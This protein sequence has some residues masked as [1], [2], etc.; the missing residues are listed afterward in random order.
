MQRRL[1]NLLLGLLFISGLQ[2]QKASDIDLA[3][4]TLAQNFDQYGLEI[5]AID[6]FLVSDHYVS[7]YHNATHLYLWQTHNNIP[8]YNG[9]IT[10]GIKNDEIYNIQSNAVRSLSLKI[11]NTEMLLSAEDAIKA[12]GEQLG[13]PNNEAFT[14]ISSDRENSF[15]YEAPSFSYQNVPVHL[16]YE[17][18]EKGTY[19]LAWQVD[20]DVPTNDYWSVRISANDGRI[21]TQ[22]NYTLYCTFGHLENHS[23]DHSCTHDVP[24]EGTNET[25]QALVNSF[26]GGSYNVYAEPA[27]S[28][29][30]GPLTIVNDPAHPTASPFGW[31]DTD[32]VEGPEFTITRGNNTSTYLDKNADN[33]SDGGEP[34]G[35]EELVF[36]FPHNQLGEPAESD[37]AAQVNLFYWNNFLHDF[38]YILGFDEPSGNFQVNNYGN[39]GIGNDPVLSEASDGSG[40]NNANFATPSDGFSGRMQMFL[41]GASEFDIFNVNSPSE[42]EGPYEARAAA[43]G[44]PISDDPVTG[45]LM[46][47]DDGTPTPTLSCEELVN[48]LTGKIAVID[49]AACEFGLKSLNAQNAGAIGVI[50]CNVAGVNGGDGDTDIFSMGGGAFGAQVTIPAIMV[51]LTDCNT[52]KASIS[53]GITVEGTLQLPQVTGP[54]Q[55][56][57]SFDNGIIA[58]ELGHGISNRLT[59]GPSQAGCL[60]N[61]EQMGE[62][63][64]DYFG[65]VT[66]VEPGDGPGDSRG[67]GTY[68]L[69]QDTDGLGI[70]D[71]PY[72]RNM[73]ISPKTYNDIIGTGAPHPLGEVWAVVTWDLYWD[74]VDEYGYDADINNLESGNAR[75]IRLV[76]EGMKEQACSPGFLSGR[77]GILAADDAIYGG[78]NFCIIY[79]AFARR[80]MGFTADQG[81]TSDRNDGTED[82]LSHPS[83]LDTLLIR[84]E[85]DQFVT[86]GEQYEVSITLRNFRQG[87]V[88]I[89]VTDDV[90]EG[91]LYVDGS[92]T[93]PVTLNGDVLT[94]DIG[95]MDVGEE[96]TFT[97]MLEALDGAESETLYFDDFSNGEDNWNLEILEGTTL[98]WEVV[99]GAITPGDPGYKIDSSSFETDN[100]FFSLD[101]YEVT[102]DRPVLKFTHRY[103]TELGFDGGFVD[104]RRQ[105]ELAWTRLTAD[106]NISNGYNVTLAFGTFALPS[107][108]AFSGDSEGVIETI[109][110]LGDYV[111]ETIQVR[112]RY[113]TDPAATTNGEFNGWAIDDFEILDLRDFTGEACAF[114]GSELINCAAATTFIQ[115]N[116]NPNSVFDAERDDFNLT[117]FP[118]PTADVVNLGIISEEAG[119]AKIEIIAVDGTTVLTQN[120][121][122][123]VGKDNVSLNVDQMPTG[124]Y[125]VK[126]NSGTQHS[127]KRLIIE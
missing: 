50:V 76:I 47:V 52:I 59:G 63:W 69:S 11:E 9:L 125:F 68:V 99:D 116:G 61:D 29:S 53:A 115:S 88:D 22:N 58:H 95:A 106:D 101:E 42:I 119:D 122:L 118:N 90:P 27:E 34:D 55:L 64:S 28:P 120:H 43:F 74:M 16:V 96:V 79:N 104:V 86:I 3:K 124:V 46:L 39:G 103:N 123:V 7:S 32:G 91:T 111:G 71:F 121:R 15:L 4:R 65:L 98:I 72:S 37:D 25:N 109:L 112:F 18:N 33:Q 24:T 19:E 14:L 40:T 23:H 60:S 75:A 84:K 62:G 56:D 49:R 83:C 41:W 17:K 8:V 77:D 2:A 44:A 1:L 92:A 13:F 70:R 94:F 114:N 107:L 117:L 31:H 10:I 82:F 6:D 97:Y 126:L 54:S 57:A 108:S 45:E 78:E 66:S 5:D 93:V 48:D 36:D 80:G 105:G 102:G 81:F 113:G 73:D 26:M 85:A 87:D 12:A 89:T 38:T 127:I 21:I 110:D 30:H 20:L 35:G 67:I 51:G 100:A